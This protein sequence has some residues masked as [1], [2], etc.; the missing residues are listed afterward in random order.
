MKRD[1]AVAV[2]TKSIVKTPEFTQLFRGLVIYLEMCL[3]VQCLSWVYARWHNQEELE[4][5]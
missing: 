4:K 2:A 5:F 3:H 1:C